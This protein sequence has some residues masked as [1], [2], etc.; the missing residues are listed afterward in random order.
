MSSRD[1]K[2]ARPYGWP[3]KPF[4]RQHPVRGFLNDPRI[5]GESRA[6]HFG[7]DISAPDGTA[8]Y[9]V[10]AGEVHL[11]SK[12]ALAVVSREGGRE[13]GYW[14][15]NP[16]VRHR[17]QVLQHDLLGHI[18]EG[19]GHVHFAEHRGNKY[20]NPLRPGGIAPYA[21]G[22]RP[23]VQSIAFSKNGQTVPPDQVSGRVDLM[24]NAFDTTPLPV[25]P[26]WN[27]MPVTPALLRW[28]VIRNGNTVV[29]WQTGVDF[30]DHMLPMEQFNEVYAPGTRQNHP[31]E[32]GVYYFYV[33]RNWD[34][35]RLPDGR[36]RLQLSASDLQGNQTVS[37]LPFTI[38][39]QAGGDQ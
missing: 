12:T 37:E 2:A 17:Q 15:I 8:V 19:W 21:D 36:Y 38:Q 10:E 5:Q 28:R 16:A 33:A 4:N 18:A 34:T 14:H 13:F 32:P 25:P 1:A 20:L 9:A 26:P 31:N 6:F 23:T 29:P 39:N 7:V 27:N 30:R 3:L 11:E 35:A 22:T 24:V